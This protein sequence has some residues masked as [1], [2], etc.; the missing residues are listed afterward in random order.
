MT[1]HGAATGSST[2]RASHCIVMPS[3]VYFYG[4]FM[5]ALVSITFTA[6]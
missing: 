2:F 3:K 5:Q 6:L 4:Y 1:S